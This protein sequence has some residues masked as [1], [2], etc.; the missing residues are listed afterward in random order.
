MTGGHYSGFNRS[1]SSSEEKKSR[2]KKCV[3]GV[4]FGGWPIDERYM[5]YFM[6]LWFVGTQREGANVELFVNLSA[7]E[8]E[9]KRTTIFF[10]RQKEVYFTAVF[11]GISFICVTKN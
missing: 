3:V 7:T 6:F 10:L 5:F 9:A 8:K 1:F 11:S 2:R 4:V